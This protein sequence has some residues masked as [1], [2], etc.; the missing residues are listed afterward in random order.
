[1]PIPCVAAIARAQRAKNGTAMRRLN[2]GALTRRCHHLRR[3]RFAGG[4]RR[5]ERIAARQRGRDGERRRRP[6]RRLRVRGSA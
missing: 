1:M 2:P 4:E 6:A 3:R 5:R